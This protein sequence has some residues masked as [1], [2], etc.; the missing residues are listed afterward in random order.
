MMTDYRGRPLPPRQIMLL[1]KGG[2]LVSSL[3]AGMRAKRKVYESLLRRGDVPA[4]DLEA[5]RLDVVSTM[6]VLL[7]AQKDHWAMAND[8]VY[9]SGL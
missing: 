9:P 4:T 7:D 6:E 1:S 8:F 5:A 3:E 2:Q